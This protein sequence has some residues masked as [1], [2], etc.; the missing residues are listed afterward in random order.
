ME[1]GIRF[2]APHITDPE[3]L[4]VREEWLMFLF[5]GQETLLARSKDGLNFTLDQ[6]FSLQIGGVPGAVELPNEKV[7]IFAAG[8]DGILS[9]VFNPGSGLSPV[10]ERGVRILGGNAMIVADPACVQRLD[11]TYY[12]IFKKR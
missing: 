9:A 1:L 5:R 10:I 8:R 6:T 12:L 4:Q 3:V 7:R 11:G 2:Q